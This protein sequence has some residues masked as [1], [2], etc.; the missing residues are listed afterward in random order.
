MKT[1]GAI[2]IDEKNDRFKV[3]YK[4]F[5]LPRTLLTWGIIRHKTIKCQIKIHQNQI[6]T[7]TTQIKLNQLKDKI[8]SKSDKK[9]S[10]LYKNRCQVK[11][12][13]PVKKS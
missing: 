7:G 10:K 3:C 12:L 13:A 2:V 9:I 5:S 8:K 11:T 1:L 6:N 4:E